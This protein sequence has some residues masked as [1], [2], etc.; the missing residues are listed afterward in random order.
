MAHS[1]L[2]RWPISPVSNHTSESA[3]VVNLLGAHFGWRTS[4]CL[5]P[6]WKIALPFRFWMVG[7]NVSLYLLT[8]HDITLPFCLHQRFRWLQDVGCVLKWHCV[9]EIDTCLPSVSIHLLVVPIQSLVVFMTL[10][11]VYTPPSIRS[12]LMHLVCCRSYDS[13]CVASPSSVDLVPWVSIPSVF[14]TAHANP[15][16]VWQLHVWW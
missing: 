11:V 7:R 6:N 14:I 2:C 10:F 4:S 15:A 1:R 9:L 16:L 12:I 3:V 13:L 5:F 8:L